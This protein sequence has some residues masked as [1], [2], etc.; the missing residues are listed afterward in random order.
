[1]E[2]REEYPNLHGLY[3]WK[4]VVVHPKSSFDE[5]R[6]LA[7]LQN[8]HIK[9]EDHFQMTT[10]DLFHGL[11]E[12]YDKIHS[13]MLKVNRTGER[14]V[15]VNQR[16]VAHAYDGCHHLLNTY[17]KESCNDLLLSLSHDGKGTL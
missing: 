6:R 5:Y 7:R 11:R 17:V 1:M 4:V 3:K 10:F 8:V 13:K 14:G 16:D 12:E 2:L 9:S 15:R